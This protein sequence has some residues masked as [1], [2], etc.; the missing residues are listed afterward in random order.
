M[1]RFNVTNTYFVG[2]FFFR[3]YFYLGWGR[4]YLLANRLPPK[5]RVGGGGLIQEACLEGSLGLMES[6][7]RKFLVHVV[8]GR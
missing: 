3:E 5:F 7:A 8:E 1:A 6:T 2:T 4:A